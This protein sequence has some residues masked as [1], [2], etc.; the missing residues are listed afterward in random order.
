MNNF[1][2]DRVSAS[3]VRSMSLKNCVSN[4]NS[5]IRVHLRYTIV[6]CK[7]GLENETVTFT[8]C[9]IYTSDSQVSYVQ[10]ICNPLS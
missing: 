2:P 1:I 8:Y 10:I 7:V 6:L 5:A 9:L 4:T 3:A